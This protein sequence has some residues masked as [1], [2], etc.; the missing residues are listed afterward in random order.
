MGGPIAGASRASPL[1][2]VFIVALLLGA[3]VFLFV[4]FSQN[5]NVASVTKLLNEV[6]S[7]QSYS[8]CDYRNYIMGPGG[9]QDDPCLIEIVKE[10]YL[11][12]PSSLPYNILKADYV[13][14]DIPSNLEKFKIIED[15]IMDDKKSPGFFIECGANDG[16]FISPTLRL[17][18]IYNWTGLL[19]EGN[20][21]PFHNLTTK[22]RKAWIVNAAACITPNANKITFFTNP[23]NTGLAGLNSRKEHGVSVQ[24][25]V[26]CIPLF[27]L[28]KALNVMEVDFFSLDVEGSELAIL[29]TVPFD[30]IKFKFLTV[31]HGLIPGGRKALQTFLESKGYFFLKEMSDSLTQ[32]SAFVHESLRERFKNFKH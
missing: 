8:A 22:N 2:K 27:T 19:I 9:L 24:L 13:N 15:Y 30:K 26:Q 7:L 5:D 23:Q 10:K 20:P 6:I 17:E 3:T 29:E 4:N 18:K 1:K 21:G 11:I 32:D 28:L 31:E 25:T 16:E 12:P 14:Q